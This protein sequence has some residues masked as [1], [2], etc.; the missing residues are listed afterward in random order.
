MALGVNFGS[1]YVVVTVNIYV[2]T[3]TF[4]FFFLSIYLSFFL[5]NPDV[6]SR[7]TLGQK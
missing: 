6:I 4:S 7:L 1:F 3:K 2:E 5:C